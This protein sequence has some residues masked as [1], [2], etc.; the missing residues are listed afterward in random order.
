MFVEIRRN[1]VFEN[2]SD[3]VR[4]RARKEFNLL[5]QVLNIY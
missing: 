2:M 3:I 4:G 1:N 5:K